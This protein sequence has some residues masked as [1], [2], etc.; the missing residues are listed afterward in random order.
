MYGNK[1]APTVVNALKDIRVTLIDSLSTHSAAVT[2]DG[3][4]YTWGNEKHRLGH[5]T[6]AKEYAPR[7]VMS[8]RNK[9][10]GVDVACGS[11][12]H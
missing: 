10:A 11:G 1:S 8:L 2:E 7:P 12:I 9:P 3:V 6:T 5:G 4:L